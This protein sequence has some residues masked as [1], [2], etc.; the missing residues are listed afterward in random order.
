MNFEHQQRKRR[1]QE[2]KDQEMIGPHFVTSPA[3]L[4]L[5]SEVS[6]NEYGALFVGLKE[7]LSVEI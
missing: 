5:R 2:S 1:K 7:R 4:A 6:A 3:L